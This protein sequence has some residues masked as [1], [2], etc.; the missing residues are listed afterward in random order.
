MPAR[1]L[2]LNGA[3]LRGLVL[4]DRLHLVVALLRPLRATQS[5]LKGLSHE[6]DFSFDGMYG[7]F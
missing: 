7:L 4:H 3:L 1:A 2:G 5:S 6:M